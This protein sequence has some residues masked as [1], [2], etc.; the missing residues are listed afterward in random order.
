MR[1]YYM[2]KEFKD[3]KMDG[4][5]GMHGRK[6]RKACSVWLGKIEERRPL[7][8]PRCRWIILQLAS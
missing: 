2:G 3:D 6:R 4:A 1:K 8:R 7:S 5:C